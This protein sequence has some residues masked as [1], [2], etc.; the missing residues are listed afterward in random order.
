MEDKEAAFLGEREA[1][2]RG[3]LSRDPDN[4]SVMSQLGAVLAAQGRVI[5]AAKLLDAAC[6]LEPR[7][8]QILC[9][10]GCFLRDVDIERDGRPQRRER[11]LE[12][13]R[14]QSLSLFREARS[15]SPSDARVLYNEARWQ[16]L[17]GDNDTEARDLYQRAVAVSGPDPHAIRSRAR[18]ETGLKGEAA[19]DVAVD[20]SEQAS[21]AGVLGN[22][23]ACVSTNASDA[24]SRNGSV[25]ASMDGADVASAGGDISGEHIRALLLHGGF[26]AGESMREGKRI[27]KLQTLHEQL[28]DSMKVIDAGFFYSE[29]K[30]KIP[31][32]NRE[33]LRHNT[34]Q[35]LL[36]VKELLR[37]YKAERV[38]LQQ[39]ARTSLLAAFKAEPRDESGI[40]VLADMYTASPPDLD[41]A[42]H[43]LQHGLEMHPTSAE[44]LGQYGALLVRKSASDEA[45]TLF[46]RALEVDPTH[47]RSMC[48]FAEALKRT[49]RRKEAL[50]LVTE[51]K[52]LSEGGDGEA[53]V[54]DTVTALYGTDGDSA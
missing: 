50:D 53:F 35:S 54:A 23:T 33:A 11:M 19:S 31:V 15:L 45:E 29:N 49:G 13:V 2:A 17:H 34:S 10:Y 16:E 25:D 47:I 9:N 30:R 12:E 27:D 48:R 39:R 36:E 37:Q 22:A 5:E 43:V 1:E 20:V 3:E 46:R 38:V 40:S 26:A 42:E 8:P 28:A 18:S 52:R 24:V 41:A 32:F 4:A 51:A 7:N 14:A 21:G 44:L 6:R